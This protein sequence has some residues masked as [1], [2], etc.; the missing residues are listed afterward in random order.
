MGTDV[1]TRMVRSLWASGEFFSVLGVS[2]LRG[3][4]FSAED[5][6][7]GAGPGGMVISY[8]FWQSEFGGQDSAIGK[9]LT[10][11]DR[12]FQIIGVT[13]PSFF[14]L[15]VGKNFDVAVPVSTRAL[16]WDNV[17]DRRDAWWLR[18]MGRLKPGSTR[19]QAAEYAKAISPG[20]MEA[21][22][23][24]GYGPGSGETYRK[25][26]LSAFAAGTGVSQ[27]RSEYERSL[28]LLLGITGLVLVTACVNLANLSLARASARAREIAVRLALGASR[29]RLI[30]QLLSESLLLAGAGAAA[31]AGLA[32]WLSRSMVWFL[33]TQGNRLNLDLDADWRVLAFTSVVAVLTCVLFGL[34]PAIRSS[35]IAPGAALSAGGRGIAGNRERFAL[36][37]GLCVLQMAVSLVL[38]SGALLLV[39]SFWNLITLHPGFRQ[40][41][42]LVTYVSF[43]HQPAERYEVLKRELLEKIRSIPQVRAASTTSHIPLSGSSWTM[44]VRVTGPQGVKDG[45]SKITWVSPDFFKTMEIPVLSG[46]DFNDR[47]TAT[48][49]KVALVNETFVRRYLGNVNPIG[50]TV[51]TGAEPN[52]PEAAYE[53]IGVVRD[54]K[55]S[56][57]RQ[58]IPP[59]AFAPAPQHPVPGPWAAIMIRSSGPLPGVIATVKQRTAEL[60]PSIRLGTSVLRTQVREGLARERLMAWLSGFFGVLAAVLVMVGLYGLIAYITWTRRNELGIRL[61]LGAQTGDILWLVLRQGLQL[62]ALGI[63]IGLAGA[64]ALTGFLRGLLFGVAP[65]DPPTLIA[66]SFLLLA[67]AFVACW[68]PARRAARIHPMEALRCE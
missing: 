2:P 40:D 43:A 33:A 29:A 50:A 63:A 10:L 52:Y 64:L 45:S 26:R 62:A 27:L 18:V 55:Y 58:E 9:S 25:C 35:R 17:L 53:V 47:D 1:E 11:G 60:D 19:A 41:G 12:V 37:R 46:R 38:L 31:G 21:T 20:I 65:T 24:T 13:P 48:S 16:W 61:A 59:I 67:V 49:P 56:N 6:L 36:Q 22:V 66:I 39:R 28:W 5:D 51:R 34:T 7:R 32:H 4:L 3:R 8:A 54:T 14:G 23:P 42:I 57:L 30:R 44:G 68:L 15:E